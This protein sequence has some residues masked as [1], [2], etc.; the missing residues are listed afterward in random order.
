MCDTCLNHSAC[1]CRIMNLISAGTYCQWKDHTPD[2]QRRPYS[3]KIYDEYQS[4]Q[5]IETVAG[6]NW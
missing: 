2:V 5:H 6:Y 4:K 1:Q 3:G